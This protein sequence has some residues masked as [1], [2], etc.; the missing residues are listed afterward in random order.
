VTSRL[1]RVIVCDVNETLLD[2]RAL[3]RA[4]YRLV[5]RRAHGE[6]YGRCCHGDDHL[7][8]LWAVG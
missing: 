6:L 3:E 2:V 5:R 1:S 4:T 7:L 8:A